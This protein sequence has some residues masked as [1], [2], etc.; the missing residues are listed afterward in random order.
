VDVRSGR[1]LQASCGLRPAFP[2]AG[3]KTR[4]DWKKTS[5]ERT[6]E[7]NL[8]ERFRAVKA[9]NQEV[10]QAR[11][12]SVKSLRREKDPAIDVVDTIAWTLGGMRR[13][14]GD[15]FP[16]G[17]LCKLLGER[18][19]PAKGGSTGAA[20]KQRRSG[21]KRSSSDQLSK[22]CGESTAVST[23]P[24][25]LKAGAEAQAGVQLEQVERL[26]RVESHPR[27]NN[28]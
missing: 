21:L 3:G 23:E 25:T 17:R 18:M 8:R 26:K 28:P 11:R 15:Y 16:G 22:D 9:L 12:R 4:F 5:L 2:S 19:R 24:M 13:Q 20:K 7:I 14:R 1:H 10:V 27:E 6:G